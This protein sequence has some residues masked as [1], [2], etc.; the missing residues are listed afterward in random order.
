MSVVLGGRSLLVLKD[1]NDPDAQQP[2]ELA[3]QSR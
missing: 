1:V 3:F 2:I